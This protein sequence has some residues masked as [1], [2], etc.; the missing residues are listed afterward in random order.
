MYVGNPEVLDELVFAR[1]SDRALS[2]RRCTTRLLPNLR[3]T[4]GKFE[5]TFRIFPEFRGVCVISRPF[6]RSQNARETERN[7]FDFNPFINYYFHILVQYSFLKKKKKESQLKIVPIS[8][9]NGSECGSA[10]TLGRCRSTRKYIKELE[11]VII[12]PTQY[13]KIIIK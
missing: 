8:D 7:C 9:Q 1:E 2:W 12:K 10:S 5:K 11:R 6:L 4:C 13:I 3:E